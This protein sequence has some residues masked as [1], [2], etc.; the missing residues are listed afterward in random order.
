MVQV[1]FA[2]DDAE[3]IAAAHERFHEGRAAG[4]IVRPSIL[5]SWQ[6]CR[7]LGL[8]PDRLEV[9]YL[10]DLDLESRL[11]RAAAPVLA[12]VESALAG[13]GV[14]MILTDGKGRVIQRRGGEPELNRRLDAIRLAVGFAFAEQ[15]AGTNGI[16]TALTDRRPCFVVGAEHFAECLYPL[17][18]AGA[19]I[20]DPLSGRV[21]GVLDLTCWRDDADPTMMRVVRD[22]A[23]TIEQRLL[24]QTT[25][26]EREF[27]D[28]FLRTNHG[29]RLLVHPP[30]EGGL[31]ELSSAD[32]V[33]GRADQALLREKAAELISSPH[34]PM[35]RVE[36]RNG[37]VAALIRRPVAGPSGET[38]IA[39]EARLSGETV[40]PRPLPPFVSGPPGQAV[41][42]RAPGTPTDASHETA[43][44]SGTDSE[45]GTAPAGGTEGWLLLVGELGVGRLA[46]QARQRLEL[47][48][49]ASVRI[50]TTLDVTRTAEELAEVVVPRFADFVAID[51]PEAVLLG[52]E[53]APDASVLRRVAFGGVHDSPL[54]QAG[55]TVDFVPSTPQ[56]RCLA[57]RQ[58]VLEADLT[59]AIGWRA[60]DPP[61]AEKILGCGIRS[62][63]AAP[64][65]A[66]GTTLGVVS[67]FRSETRDA[68]EDDDLYIAEELVGRAGLCIDNARRFTRERTMALALQRSLL[69]RGL[70]EHGAVEVAHRYLPAQAGVSGDWYDVIPLSGSRVALAV[71][72][73]VGHGM[74]AAVTMGR[75]RTAVQNFA[76]LDLP[77][78]DVLSRLDDLVDRLDAD[79]GPAEPG[80]GGGN[81]IVGA[82]CLYAVYDPVSMRCTVARAG[83]PL[84]A[85][86]LP[87]GT[88]E[89]PD[90]PAGPPLGLGGLPFEPVELD[91]PDGSR[92][93]L[94][95]DGL[96]EQRRRDIDVGLRLLRDALARSGRSPE[97]TC[98][99]VLHAL[100]PGRPS[101][102]VAL[103]VARMHALEPDK[104][105]VWDVGADPANVGPAREAVTSQLA[106]WGLEDLAFTTELMV[107][108]L[109]TNA[110]RYAKEPIQVRLLR[111]HDT[112]IC[113]VSDG[114]STS[115]RMRRA[116]N[117][118]EGG[119]GLF[120]I[121]Q[122][123]TR[124]G[125]RY[126][127][128]GK[129]IWAEQK[130]RGTASPDG[131]RDGLSVAS[132]TR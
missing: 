118:D 49:D 31:G 62:L 113:E 44:A 52:E 94:Y 46:L 76:A 108:E 33:L 89:F 84:P 129:V 28:A 99:A 20:R 92:L 103:L 11:C 95:T 117:T 64:M 2:W 114:S 83:H 91:I 14:S 125:T 35:A 54:F 43:P 48:Y 128:S 59:E 96:I 126:T 40:P 39:V 8:V 75:L 86:V 23:H 5:T 88:V 57:A 16:G 63:I 90:V 122:L 53:P 119:R 121:A 77:V 27:L 132:P 18:C 7:S 81:G 115:P 42:V 98:E 71:G 65:R 4:R 25:A 19:P 30:A 41:P 110:I 79:Q 85:L 82:S 112:L 38:G 109:A 55:D 116:A 131:D 36:L 12:K 37:Q 67:F 10:E 104:V 70:P 24:E 72:D 15:T 13:T 50:G 73:V 106:R 60:V 97:D 47:L 127:K 120:L 61:R 58:A 17:A 66:R 26:R 9:P 124:W 1:A 3:S 69:P 111:D 101:D 32:E 107:S 78:E 22:A 80:L 45:S 34:L 51:L 6:R 21:E 100:L 29:A 68:F 123:A 87:D 105:A 56:A 130:V 74:H 93:V 102:D